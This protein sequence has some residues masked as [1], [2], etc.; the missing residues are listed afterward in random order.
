MSK[1]LGLEIV[2]GSA[3]GG[4]M[5]GFRTVM[6]ETTK[7]GS[8]VEN[9]NKKRVEIFDDIDKTFAP[10]IAEVEKRIE[11][12]RGFEVRLKASV[13]VN[14]EE[15][16]GLEREIK[17]TEKEIRALEKAKLNLAKDFEAGKIEAADFR[18]AV[19][20]V[21][22][23]LAGLNGKKFN[24]SKK[25]D[26]A[27]KRA[28]TLK[29]RLQRTSAVISSLSSKKLKLADDLDRAKKKAAETNGE[30]KRLGAAVENLNKHKIRIGQ[31]AQKREM[32]RSKLVDTVAI[33]VTA[34]F[35]VKK[36]IEFES[37]MAD[38]VK[39]ANL[40]ESETKKFGAALQRLSTQI[41]IAADGLAAI[42]ASGA[43]LGI[44]KEKLADFTK[45]VAK[46]STAFDMSADA[47]GESVAKLMNVYGLGLDGVSKLGDALNHLSDNTA[48]KASDMVQVLARI[49]GTAKV[50][51]LTAKEAA[52]LSDAF[53]AMG[54]PPEVAATAI[55][56]LLTKLSTADKQ[57]RKFQEGL[58]AL[59]LSSVEIKM[60]VENDPQ[61]AI[62][63]VLEAVKDLDRQSRMGVLSDL[64]GAEYG[65]DIALLVGG[66]ENYKKA[67]R[68]TAQEQNYLGSMQ[69]EFENRSKTTANKLQLLKNSFDRIGVALGSVILPPL[70]TAADYLAKFFDGLAKLNEEFPLVGKAIG[71]ATI[72]I[73][74]FVVASSALGY[75]AT[76]VVSGLSKAG[77]A[78]TLLKTSIGGVAARFGV[79]TFAT[80]AYAAASR[81]LGA[82]AG[83]LGGALKA[84]GRGALW[85]GRALLANPVGIAVAAI[86]G[87][88][89]LIYDNWEKLGGFLTSLWLKIKSVFS[90]AWGGIEKAIS[91][92][93]LG[94]IVKMWKPVFD[95]LGQKFAWVGKAVDKLASIGTSVKSFFG[96]GGDDKEEKREKR[97]KSGGWFGGW[98]GDDEEEERPSR[99]MGK[100]A[101][102]VATAAT[103]G[104]T[105]VAAE[106]V[107]IPTQ[108][109]VFAKEDATQSSR[110]GYA[111]A[112][113]KPVT[114]DTVAP[115][116][117]SVAV[118]RPDSVAIET[119]APKP[120]TPTI[121]D[122]GPLSIETV[123]PEPIAPKIIEP[124]PVSAVV[125]APMP[126]TVPV[127]APPAII[128]TVIPPRPVNIGIT[129]PD[130]IK[131]VVERSGPI[132]PEVMAPKP[133]IPTVMPGKHARVPVHIDAVPP[134]SIPGISAPSEMPAQPSC[135]D[136]TCA[137]SATHETNVTIRFGDIIVQNAKEAPEVIKEKIKSVIEEIEFDRFQVGLHDV[138]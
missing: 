48:A 10:K 104:A 111:T 9:L 79:A 43:Q 121:Q 7:L 59:G 92:S 70:Q 73:G 3:I 21:D 87:G 105:L 86:A 130:P 35:P 41:P 62:M 5:N 49:G 33:G 45:I 101:K 67:L 114:I 103:L 66:L 39:V 27:Q 19:K 118:S 81:G 24:L 28:G 64:F 61:K 133:T 124:A 14:D 123:L 99:K 71:F 51:G 46:M 25:L 54:K 95:W 109:S 80:N 91:F 136:E 16:K 112:Q 12:L 55:N 96:F 102:K 50:F 52:A 31:M 76:F 131:P 126:V 56:A 110:Y 60:A 65:D 63:A 84:A 83:M 88:A 116:P 15:V 113:S 20:R 122:P 68:L 90:W 77:M 40:S 94:I 134:A 47:A 53:L 107:H 6:S 13:R 132:V 98:F 106:P 4:A 32:F 42:A 128:P 138:V 125:D 36:A 26:D 29:N 117:I 22:R 11:K 97:K 34:A 137:P 78:F 44:A 69:R 119:V 74:G 85:L 75:A 135:V 23:E 120:I 37:A 89:W 58:A 17:A 129:A 93:P 100:T 108:K 30:L 127:D 72:G 38:V 115:D 8:A 1:T 57:G 2:I 82:A 18:R